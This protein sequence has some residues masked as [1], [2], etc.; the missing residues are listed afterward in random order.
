MC[1]QYFLYWNMFL[2]FLLSRSIFLFQ[3]SACYQIFLNQKNLFA[4]S[5]D[6]DLNFFLIKKIDL[7]ISLDAY[8]NFFNQKTNLHLH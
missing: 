5:L 3:N 2:T 7:H 8:L 1:C 6:V 4:S